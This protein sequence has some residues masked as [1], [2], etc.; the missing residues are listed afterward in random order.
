M[1]DGA[2]AVVKVCRMVKVGCKVAMRMDPF[3]YLSD[4]RSP[5]ARGFEDQRRGRQ[6]HAGRDDRRLGPDESSQGLFT[7]P[8]AY[9]RQSAAGARAVIG[10]KIVRA[11]MC[12][13]VDGSKSMT[14]PLTFPVG[15]IRR[16]R[17]ASQRGTTTTTTTTTTTP[18]PTPTPTTPSGARVDSLP[19]PTDDARDT[20]LVGSSKLW[21]IDRLTKGYVAV[22]HPG[23][24]VD[25]V[26]RHEARNLVAGEDVP[27]DGG[28]IGV[29]ADHVPAGASLAHVVDG[30]EDDGVRVALE[31][32]LERERVVMEAEH[33]GALG[34]QQHRRR[35]R[36]RVE[37]ASRTADV[38]G[39]LVGGA[40]A[41][42]GRRRA[43][44]RASRGARP[45]PPAGL[46]RQRHAGGATC[47]RGSEVDDV[48]R[49][50]PLARD[51]VD[52]GAAGR[53]DASMCR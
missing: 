4:K 35:R 8:T 14:W 48:R 33:G 36:T 47:R 9:V 37:V 43:R 10:S 13:D 30:D 45:R 5:S 17:R 19:P 38:D 25:V 31:A 41:G 29:V 12:S 44:A 51:A 40:V 7:D 52:D 42:V 3:W 1:G 11:E 26:V 34:V 39:A 53:E 27:D 18:T 22:P 46:I 15:M 23:R 50:R 6:R 24:D 16:Q 49:R 32:S 20:T 21:G 2:W 28:L